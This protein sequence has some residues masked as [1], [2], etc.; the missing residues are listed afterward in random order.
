[1]P[2]A[3]VHNVSSVW[4]FKDKI[5][6]WHQG[7]IR[8]PTQVYDDMGEPGMDHRWDIFEQLHKR[9]S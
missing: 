4:G 1:M 5:I 9:E 3:E 7:V 2:S 8:I 6:A